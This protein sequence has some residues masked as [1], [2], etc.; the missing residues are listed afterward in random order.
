M[1]EK[2]WGRGKR[3]QPSVECS[4]YA[5]SQGVAAV[6]AGRGVAVGWPCTRA[7]HSGNTVPS[8]CA[9]WGRTGRGARAGPHA[10]ERGGM[11]GRRLGRLSPGGPMRPCG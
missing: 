4:T 9:A 10:I 6:E 5:R 3:K 7:D 11:E 8:A 1:V 2:K